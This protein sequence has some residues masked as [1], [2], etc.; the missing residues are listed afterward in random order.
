MGYEFSP[1]GGSKER[2]FHKILLKDEDNKLRTYHVHLIFKGSREW[3]NVIV[4]RNYLRTHPK[5]VKKYAEIKKFGTQKNNENREVYMQIKCPLIDDMVEK[6]LK[7]DKKE[8]R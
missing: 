7:K 3:D 8:G 6:A 2:L 5:E 1:K 4:F